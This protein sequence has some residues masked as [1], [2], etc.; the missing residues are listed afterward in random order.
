MTTRPGGY[1][2]DSFG[3]IRMGAGGPLSVVRAVA[4][5]GQ[6]VRVVFNEEPVHVSAAG[7]ADALNPANYWLEVPAGNA[8]APVPVGVDPDMVIGPTYAVGNGGS[9]N[10]RGFDVA[11]DRQ[12]VVGVTYKISVRNLQSLAGGTLGTP[13]AATFPG[14]TKLQETLLPQRNQDLVDFANPPA[15]GHWIFDASED[16]S[17][18]APDA[19]TRKRIWRRGFTKK[20]SYVHL[21]GYGSAIDHKGVAGPA[22]MATFRADYQNQ[23]QQEPDVAAASVTANIQASG[24]AIIQV[25]A[26]TIRGTFVDT[27]GKVTTD[28][29]VTS[30]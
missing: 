11:V 1:G 25:S 2:R 8:T 4:V 30:L 22:K 18:E 21:P 28:G 19:G 16:I 23:I 17:P 6:V 13:F 29:Q 5:A 27:G 7:A 20:N 26:K 10:E 14:V 9:A 24:V 3:A 12:L 15:I